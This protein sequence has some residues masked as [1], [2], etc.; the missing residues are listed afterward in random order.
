MKIIRVNDKL[1]RQVLAELRKLPDFAYVASPHLHFFSNCREQGYVLSAFGQG[2]SVSVTFAENRSSDDVVVYFS[3]M[4][5]IGDDAAWNNNGHYKTP[6]AAATAIH[7]FIGDEG[8]KAKNAAKKRQSFEERRASAAAK[9][10]ER[11]G[12]V[13]DQNHLK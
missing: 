13:V 11:L 1:A 12:G 5:N 4:N 7:R 9:N 10:A 6:K 2:V 3:D 8:E